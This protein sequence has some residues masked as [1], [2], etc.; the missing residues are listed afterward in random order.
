MAL[1]AR[2]I[3]TRAEFDEVLEGIECLVRKHTAKAVYG[4]FAVPLQAE[5]AVTT[6]DTSESTRLGVPCYASWSSSSSI[7]GGKPTI[8]HKEFLWVGL[9]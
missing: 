8:T 3:N 9:L 2:S 5:I 6:L 7:E 4:V 1:G